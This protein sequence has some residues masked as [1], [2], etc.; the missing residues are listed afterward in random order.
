MDNNKG[1]RAATFPYLNTLNI[2]KLRSISLA[3]RYLSTCSPAEQTGL[4]F[5]YPDPR[6]RRDPHLYPRLPPGVAF[7]G[8]FQNGILWLSHGCRIPPVVSR[9]WKQYVL[10][11]STLFYGV[12]SIY[13]SRSDYAPLS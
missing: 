3:N 12:D 1:V 13:L 9:G 5:P 6:C 11:T 7:Q 8:I 4:Q 10:D 2:D